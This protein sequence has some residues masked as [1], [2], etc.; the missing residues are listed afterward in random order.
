[1]DRYAVF[2]S[3]FFR[4]YAG[5]W[6]AARPLLRRN[7]RLS[8]GWAERCVPVDWM[9]G[10]A[11]VDLWVQAASGGEAHLAVALLH[12]LPERPALRV[13]V[14]TWTRQGREVIETALPRPGGRPAPG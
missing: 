3:L 14:A 10:E 7:K 13:L 4:V 2:S 1:M 9:G 8:D 5:L 11:P 12:A 6:R